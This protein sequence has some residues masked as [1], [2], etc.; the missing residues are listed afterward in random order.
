MEYPEKTRARK[1]WEIF[2]AYVSSMLFAFTGG[3]VTLPLLQQQLGDKYKLI[4]REQVLE[5]F[6]LGQA[7][8]GVI[9]VNVGVLVG[10]H[11]AGPL[12]A[13]AAVAGTVLPAFIGMLVI[14]LSY[15][16]LAGIEI[17]AGIIGGIR[18]ASVAIILVNAIVILRRAKEV[19]HIVLAAFALFATL[20]L[21][22]NVLAV[23]LLC[24]AAGGI[25]AFL[26]STN[27]GPPR[28]E[29]AAT[30]ADEEVAD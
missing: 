24:A 4:S 11:I 18:A 3:S 17:I 13:A 30:P 8:P 10:L 19:F 15:T 29:S 26:R 12:G 23:I 7:L 2:K 1:T 28:E 25:R 22:W 21:G 5:Y 14:A 9:S 27:G 6:A 20:V 16:L